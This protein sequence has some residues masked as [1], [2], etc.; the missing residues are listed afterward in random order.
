M[1]VMVNLGIPNVSKLECCK[2][3]ERITV[4]AA[5]LVLVVTVRCWAMIQ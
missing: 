2:L 4:S 3:S 5:A 1:A